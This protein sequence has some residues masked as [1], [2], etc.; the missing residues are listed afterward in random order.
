MTDD[1]LDQLLQ[2]LQGEDLESQEYDFLTDD[3]ISAIGNAESWC[4]VERCEDIDCLLC[5]IK[6]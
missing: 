2:D 5:E 3:E 1:E 6:P 4:E